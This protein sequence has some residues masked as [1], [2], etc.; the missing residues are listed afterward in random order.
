MVSSD[1]VVGFTI[2]ETQFYLFSMNYQSLEEGKFTSERN[3]RLVDKVK[4]QFVY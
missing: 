2:S 4:W 3:L 1:V